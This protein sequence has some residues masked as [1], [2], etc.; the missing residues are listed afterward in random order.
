MHVYYSSLH[1]LIVGHCYPIYRRLY[2]PVTNR[3]STWVQMK[4]ANVN[5]F[6]DLM[7]GLQKELREQ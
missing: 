2:R 5:A 3:L 6:V 1:V 4:E 7:A